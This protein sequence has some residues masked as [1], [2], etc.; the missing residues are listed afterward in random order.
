MRRSETRPVRPT[1]DAAPPLSVRETVLGIRQGRLRPSDPLSDCLRRIAG[2]AELNAF[3]WVNRPAPGGE[4][5]QARRRLRPLEGVPIALKDNIDTAGIPTT[6]GS[7]QDRGR[8]PEC[9]ALVWSTLRDRAGMVLAGK[10]HMSEF[11]YRAHHA[12]LGRPRNP[13][14]LDRASGGS[15]SGSAVAVAAGLVPVALGTDT[16]GSVRIPAAYCGVVGLKGTYDQASTSG[17]VPLSPSMDH[18]GVLARSVTDAALV[19]EQ[20][21]RR[22][23]QLVDTKTLAVAASDPRTVR[24]GLAQGYLGHGAQ[25]GVLDAW[26]ATVHLLQEAGCDVVAVDVPSAARWRAAHKAILLFE[27]SRVH[28]ER[29]TGTPRYGSVFQAALNAG[30]RIPSSRYR[31]ALEERRQAVRWMGRL[32]E[33]EVDVLTTPTCPTA[34]PRGDEGVSGVGYTRYTTLAAFTGL[35]A[36]SIPVGVNRL[37]LPIGVQ[38]VAAAHAE[39]TLVGVAALLESLLAEA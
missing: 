22:P 6:S 10:T 30:S 13:H 2:H 11:A 29:L 21:H 27:A 31:A 9:D 35:P 17:I 14:V 18:V 1:L 34:A 5:V 7:L 32:F 19:F 20:V 12:T 4:L 15:S 28:S 23:L 33:R 25:T 3:L 16:G 38:L 26:R 8:I 36:I 24:L 39:G 37:G